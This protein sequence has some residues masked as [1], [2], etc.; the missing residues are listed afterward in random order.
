MKRYI[1]YIWLAL[2]SFALH[3]ESID[4]LFIRV[5]DNLL[6]LLELNARLD[7]LD[8]YNCGM[9][10]KAENAYKGTSYLTVKSKHF[11][12]LQLTDISTWSLKR[13]A[14][15]GDTLFSCIH[16]LTHPAIASSIRFFNPQWESVDIEL[17]QP[18]DSLFWQ[19]TDSL[20]H[21]RITELRSRINFSAV[22]AFWSPEVDELTLR[23]SVVDLNEEDRKD[24]LLCLRPATYV[25]RNK[26]FVLK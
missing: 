19:P 9:K 16:T 7:L 18:A 8:L 10:A 23:I 17:P 12:H 4:S 26:K 22:T 6:P 15:E 3:A 1:I 24:A 13:L 20:S 5:P 11:L 14:T 2:Q 21:E 25:W